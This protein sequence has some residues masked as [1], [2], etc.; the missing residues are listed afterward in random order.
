MAI[1]IL[2]MATATQTMN[3]SVNTP[4][5]YE[6]DHPYHLDISGIY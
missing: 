4:N 1:A 6:L 5:L 3:I 2:P